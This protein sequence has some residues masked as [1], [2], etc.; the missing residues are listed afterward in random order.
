MQRNMFTNRKTSLIQSK[1]AF[2]LV[3][4]TLAIVILMLLVGVL[5]AMVT[6]TLGGAGRLQA[7]QDRNRATGAFLSLCR[8][9]FLDMPATADF[10]ARVVT[11]GRYYSSEL[12]FRHAQGLFRFGENGNDAD[13]GAVLGVRNQVGGLVGVALLHDDDDKIGT[14]LHGSSASRPWLMLLPDL[15]NAEWRFY[16]ADS[17]TWTKEWHNATVR[18]AYA[19]L[20]LTTADGSCT[21]TFWLPPLAKPQGT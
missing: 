2:T 9:S 16:D 8:K 5:Y 17:R 7:A 12:I 1:S 6:A 19:E 14:Y 18:P 4:V 11:D 21:Y 15:R 3:E 10:E 13:S 20:T